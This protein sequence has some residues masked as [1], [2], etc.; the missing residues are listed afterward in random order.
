MYD[1]VIIGAGVTGAAAAWALSRLQANICVLE[2]D[3]DVC[4]GTSK[5]NSAIIHGG[6]DPI[7]G[8]LMAKLNVEGSEMMEQLC[9]KLDVPFRRNGALV[10]CNDNS[11]LDALEGLLRRGEQ[12]GVKGLRIVRGEELRRMEPNLS[13]SVVAALYAPTSGIV[14]PFELTLALAENAYDNGVDFHFHAEVTDIRK[15]EKGLFHVKAGGTEYITRAV[16]NAAGV[17]ADRIHNMVSRKQI[18][19]T[20]RR[21]EYCLYDK[22]LGGYV[23]H[24]IFQLPTEK[25]KG[26]LVTPTVHGNILAGPT[27]DLIE[28]KEDTA[29]TA[30]GLAEVLEKE[31]ISVRPLPKGKIITSFA[32]LRAHGDTGDFIIGEAEDAPLFYDLAGIESPGL[33]SAPAIGKMTADWAQKALNLQTKEH[34]RETRKGIPCFSEL[35]FEERKKLIAENPLYGHMVCR[36]ETVTEGEIVDAIRRPLGARSLDGVK[37]RTRAGMGRC[38]SGFCS[39]MVMEILHRETKIPLDKITKRGGDSR[40]VFGYTKDEHAKDASKAARRDV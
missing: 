27:S 20:P 38:Q 22:E 2:R 39:P 8:S 13:D 37:R 35:S 9:E 18:H 24:T 25:G 16:I 28:D 19:I 15:D 31:S 14:C 40:I 36:C 1:I 26:V 11:R 29:T 33:S 7:P 32:G 3:E 6:F 4:T 30:R 10:V 5:A 34:C 17:Y 23:Q 12:N 21:G